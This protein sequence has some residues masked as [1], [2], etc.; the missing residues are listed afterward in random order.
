MTA[1]LWHRAVPVLPSHDLMTT[2]GFWGSLGFDISLLEGYLLLTLG[3][4]ELHYV[5]KA[6]V[7]PFTTAWT[8]YVRVTNADLL[9][10]EIYE[11]D[12]MPD[13]DERGAGDREELGARWADQRDVSRLG[14]LYDADYGMR[15]FVIFDP[16]N[17]QITCGHP[18]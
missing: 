11:T 6:D 2:A 7:D 17:N 3:E 16:T 14:V 9:H 4:V 8:A 15:E 1:E 18:L 10:A 5:E 13:L 12:V